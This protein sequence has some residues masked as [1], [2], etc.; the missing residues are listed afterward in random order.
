M[1]SADLERYAE[2]PDDGGERG[3]SP[4][5]F[6]ARMNNLGSPLF[7]SSSSIFWLET[8]EANLLLLTQ[9]PRY[10]LIRTG[11]GREVA[12]LQGSSLRGDA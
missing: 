5:T 12:S 1:D 6:G 11:P 2:S 10:R 3:G 4:D 8:R 9:C 7:R